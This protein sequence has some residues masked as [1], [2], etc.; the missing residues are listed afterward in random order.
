MSEAWVLTDRVQGCHS[1]ESK[2]PAAKEGRNKWVGRMVSNWRVKEL[3]RVLLWGR[4]ACEVSHYAK[5]AMVNYRFQTKNF[6]T[7]TT[8]VSDPPGQG[9]EHTQHASSEWTQTEKR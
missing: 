6:I 2:T 8:P 3:R 1:C 5:S 9:E 4:G 7:L